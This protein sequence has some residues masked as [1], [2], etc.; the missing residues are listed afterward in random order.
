MSDQVEQRRPDLHRRYEHPA[1]DPGQREAGEAAGQ[2]RRPLTR[3]PG[4]EKA[5]ERQ[6]EQAPGR[7]ISQLH[8]GGE[9]QQGNDQRQRREPPEAASGDRPIRDPE[10]QRSHG[11]N[12]QLSVVTRVDEADQNGG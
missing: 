3:A 4:L 2:T 9:H 5:K 12:E 8:V 1:H 6:D 11:G 10:S 7:V